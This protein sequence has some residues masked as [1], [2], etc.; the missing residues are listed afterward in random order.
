MFLLCQFCTFLC[1]WLLLILFTDS[2]VVVAFLV[3]NIVSSNT[4]YENERMFILC[5]YG[6]QSNNVFKVLMEED[7][8]FQS[9][10]VFY[11]LL[12]MLYDAVNL[13][14]HREG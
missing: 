6:E 10:G 12:Y 9:H 11:I 7:Y 5:L 14:L 13:L 4:S 8:L 1:L 3:H 2:F